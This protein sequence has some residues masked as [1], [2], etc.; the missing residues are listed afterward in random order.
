[1]HFG[2]KRIEG[3]KLQV[4]LKGP[5]YAFPLTMVL[6]V[7]MTPLPKLT[8]RMISSHKAVKHVSRLTKLRD[9]N[10]ASKHSCFLLS[11]WRINKHNYMC[12][13]NPKKV[14]YHPPCEIPCGPTPFKIKHQWPLKK[15]RLIQGQVPTTLESNS[16]PKK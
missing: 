13:F 3:P 6:K 15:S 2:P 11:L 10:Q 7:S 12:R 8:S 9:T 5:S 4:R 1:M 16:T 14:E